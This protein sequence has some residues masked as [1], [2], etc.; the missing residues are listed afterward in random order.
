MP[1][2]WR[3]RASRSLQQLEESVASSTAEALSPLR[4]YPRPALRAL[5][6]FREALRAAKAAEGLSV[7]RS[8]T[9]AAAR[10]CATLL[11]A[12]S[13]MATAPKSLLEYC[14][15]PQHLQPRKF[16]IAQLCLILV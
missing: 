7:P 5:P 1:A 3:W 12:H 4:G 11:G 16:P 10:E 15:I 14:R 8:I 6:L 13:R 2:G 9:A